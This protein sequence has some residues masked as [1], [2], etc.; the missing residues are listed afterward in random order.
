M[1]ASNEPH[2]AWITRLLRGEIVNGEVGVPVQGGPFDGRTQIVKLDDAGR[3]PA[4]FRGRRGDGAW[5]RY[6]LSNEGLAP[7]SWLYAFEGAEAD[8]AST[9]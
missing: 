1:P 3:P 2:L 6:G 7:S 4:S 5:H 8:D 9:P